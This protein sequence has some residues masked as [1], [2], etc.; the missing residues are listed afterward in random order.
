MSCSRPGARRSGS[1]TPVPDIRLPDAI[2]CAHLILDDGCPPEA[3]MQL[4]RMI[5]D[6]EGGEACRRC[7]DLYLLYVASGRRRDPYECDRLHDQGMIG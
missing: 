2:G 5:E 4:C 1:G 7:W 3:G 6:D